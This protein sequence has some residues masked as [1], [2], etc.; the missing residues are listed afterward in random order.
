M[1]ANF[2]NISLLSGS[3]CWVNCVW[4]RFKFQ[5]INISK[6][7][8]RISQTEEFFHLVCQ[9]IGSCDGPWSPE[10]IYWP[11]F[12]LCRVQ[13]TAGWG[14][15]SVTWTDLQKFVLQLLWAAQLDDGWMQT[16]CPYRVGSCLKK[17]V[18][19]TTS[20]QPMGSCV[21]FVSDKVSL[22]TRSWFL[23]R[24]RSQREGDE[25]AERKNQQRKKG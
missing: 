1:H 13:L 20:N 22:N 23:I 15:C 17:K 5:W 4:L 7:T 3:W 6:F 9:R 19:R 16:P 2:P 11:L 14:Q 10:N 25:G 24:S 21:C 12:V 18:S 8:R